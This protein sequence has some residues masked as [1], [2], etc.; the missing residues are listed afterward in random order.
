VVDDNAINRRV[1]RSFLEHYRLS[2]E[3]ARDGNEALAVLARSPFDIVLMDI[4][5]PGLDGMEA[6]RKLRLS[7]SP[8]RQTPVIALTAE[9]MQGDRERYLSQGFDDY[10]SKPIDE[11]TLMSALSRILGEPEQTPRQA[12]S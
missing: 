8:N 11:R 5:M 9:S 7:A 3:E 10:I 1:A 6:F 2:V 12:A 4:Q